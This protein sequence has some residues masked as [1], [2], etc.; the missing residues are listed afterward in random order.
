LKIGELGDLRRKIDEID[1]NIIV[2]LDKRLRLCREIGKI[3]KTYRTPI[4][5][6]SRELEVLKRAGSYSRIFREII[7]V[8]KE[9]Q[10]MK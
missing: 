1:E 7:R 10:R 3:K 9:A 8:C 6:H 2:L 4:T 5:D